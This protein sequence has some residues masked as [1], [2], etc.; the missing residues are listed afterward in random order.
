[1][2]KTTFLKFEIGSTDFDFDDID[3]NDDNND[4]DESSFKS[5]MQVDHEIAG[6]VE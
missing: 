5:P 6:D 2:S 3:D 4:S 1:M